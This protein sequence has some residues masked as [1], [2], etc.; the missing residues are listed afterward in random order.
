[1]AM[2]KKSDNNAVAK[3]MIIEELNKKATEELMDL[4]KELRAARRV[5]KNVKEKIKNRKT[6]LAEDIEEYK[7]L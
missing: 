4:L 7:N 5:V 3:E 1:M 2:T 6:Q